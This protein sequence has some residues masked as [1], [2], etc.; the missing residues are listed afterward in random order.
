MAETAEEKA[1]R[2]ATRLG[3]EPVP[4]E[5][6]DEKKDEGQEPSQT[7][8]GQAPAQQGGQTPPPWGDDFTPERAWN[9]MQALRGEVRDLKAE[10]TQREREAMSE[11]DR[12]KAELADVKRELEATKLENLRVTV[13]TAKGLAPDAAEFLHG[14]TQE[15]LEQSAD[16]LKRLSGGGSGTTRTPDFGG[17]ARPNGNTQM[18]DTEAFSARLR[19]EAG[20]SA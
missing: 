5:K 17:G 12:T 4:D 13:A 15:E 1:Q 2:L 3:G 6:A 20:R 8:A 16:K 10:K 14:A 18:T 19:R 11:A 9:T 7:P